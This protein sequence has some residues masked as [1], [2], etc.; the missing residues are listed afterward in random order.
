MG[1]VVGADTDRNPAK[2]EVQATQG[3]GR[4]QAEQGTGVGQ[5]KAKIGAQGQA[6]QASSGN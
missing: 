5:A 6:R 3:T 1:T 4:N 2:S